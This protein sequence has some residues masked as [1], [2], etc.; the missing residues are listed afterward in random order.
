[1]MIEDYFSN[2]IIIM[3]II[4]LILHIGF[5]YFYSQLAS[6]INLIDM[7]SERKLH[8]GKIPLVGGVSIF[9][10]LTLF[11]IFFPTPILLKIIFLSSFLVLIISLLDDIYDVGITE[12]I[13]F[14]TVATLIVVGFGVRIIDIGTYNNATIYLGGFGIVL[15]CLTIIAF[16]NAINF[17][18]GLDGLA[19]GYILN[20]ILSIIFFSYFFKVNSDLSHL[21][22]LSLLLIIFLFSNHGFLL[23]KTF[24][25]DNGSASLGFLLSCFLVY[26]TLP[27]NRHFH[28]VLTLWATPFPI[29][30]FMT[31]F[32]R[33]MLKRTNPFKP[34]RRHMHYLLINSKINNKFIPFLLVGLSFL[35][36]IIGFLIFIQFGSISSLASFFFILVIYFLASVYLSRLNS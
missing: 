32:I 5:I 9:T 31:V 15:S 22:F 8:I 24:L 3:I 20:C 4:L 28:P 34:D 1:M 18:D 14:Q 11:Y 35:S 25:G 13:F 19:T 26:Y 23:P 12:R 27:D 17:S 16:T 2:H 10:S 30:D 21:F 6:R 29:L 36:S 33:R 7:P